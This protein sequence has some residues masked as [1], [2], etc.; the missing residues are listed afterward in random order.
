[1]KLDCH[2][3][4]ALTEHE[5]YRSYTRR[6]G[7]DQLLKMWQLQITTFVLDLS[8]IV[9]MENIAKEIVKLKKNMKIVHA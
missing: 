8:K 5:V 3:T 9:I 4:Q 1:M 7:K 6:F 2:L